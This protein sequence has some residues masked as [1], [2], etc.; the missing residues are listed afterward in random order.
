[1]II[2]SVTL[3]RA[4]ASGLNRYVEGLL[5]ELLL[6]PNTTAYTSLTE[7]QASYNSQVNLVSHSLSQPGTKA[8][9][10]RFLWY[11]TKL[12]L[13]LRQQKADLFYSPVPE[14][15][16]FPVCKQIVT[17]ADLV[18][19]LFPEFMPV[20]KY[21]FR[22]ILPRLL[23][24]STAI[25]TISEATK[26]DVERHYAPVDKPI[27]VVYPSYDE[28]TFFARQSWEVEAVKDKYG[29]DQFILSVGEM[30]PYKNI[31]RLIEA[32]SRVEAPQIKL[33]IVGKVNKLDPEI[34][35]LPATLGITEKVKFLN[36]VSDQDLAAL[37]SSARL[38]IFPSLYEGFG[39]PLLEAMA[40][41]CPIIASD[42]SSLPEVA[43][44]AAIYCNPTDIDNIAQKIHDLSSNE[45]LR[46]SLITNGTERVKDFTYKI[47]A[48]KVRQI[49]NEVKEAH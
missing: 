28:Q 22:Y 33:A 13:L 40:C 12:P 45:V 31:R 41:K 27:H 47:S 36:Y 46:Q 7:L 39:I 48:D 14:G 2:N 44:D 43:G 8:N 38:F 17:V 15:M 11:Q 3:N 16:L 42:S 30:R 37:Y 23:K 34:M 4:G 29:L 6:Q 32:F 20:Q 49:C 10:R 26:R 24:A 19:V 9:F 21:Y 1:M 25:V 18:A 5:R 35:Q